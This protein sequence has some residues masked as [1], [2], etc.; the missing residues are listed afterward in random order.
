MKNSVGKT[1]RTLR[2]SKNLTQKELGNKLG[3][4]PRTV[5]DWEAGNTEPDINTIK[6]LVNFFDI[7]YDEFFDE[8]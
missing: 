4:S 5:S 2:Q 7:T 3:Y 6:A 1:I 8:I